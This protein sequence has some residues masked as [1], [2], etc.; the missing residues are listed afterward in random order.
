M[1]GWDLAEKSGCVV[2]CFCPRGWVGAP[3]VW[4]EWMI[5]FISVE[6]GFG[7]YFTISFSISLSW[8]HAGSAFNEM[9]KIEMMWQVLINT[10][11]GIPHKWVSPGTM[12]HCALSKGHHLPNPF[13]QSLTNTS[14]LWQYPLPVLTVVWQQSPTGWHH[15]LSWLFL[16]NTTL[17]H[18]EGPT[19]TCNALKKSQSYTRTGKA[20]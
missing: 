8:L 14:H 19:G 15:I 13:R 4:V 9:Q 5:W 6:V 16:R 20:I 7:I 10:S 3:C 2:T 17:S 11:S 12:Q 18:K 1:L